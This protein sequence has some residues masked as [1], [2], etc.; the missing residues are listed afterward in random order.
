MN[1]FNSVLMVFGLLLA[2]T[3]GQ[4]QQS[5]AFGHY[6]VHYNTINSDQIEPQVAKSYGIKRSA[7]RALVTITVIDTSQGASG[8]PINASVTV[9]AV[10][11]TGQRRDIDIREIIEPEEA[12]YYI[13]ELP[14]HNL[15]TYSFSASVKVPDENKPF[16]LKFRQ[17]FYTE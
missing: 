9:E 12:V 17:Q 6:V 13:G 1:R 4:A 14:I 10:N 3:N 7:N 2:V 11:L 5:H 16:E 15:E 8:T